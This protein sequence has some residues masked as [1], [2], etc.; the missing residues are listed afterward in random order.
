[1][2]LK[3]H[4]EKNINLIL[5]TDEVSKFNLSIDLKLIQ[6]ENNSCMLLT[7]DVFIFPKIIF[8]ILVQFLNIPL[9]FITF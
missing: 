9:I 8:F 6:Q 4:S 3:T 5:V 2:C 1:M 7:E